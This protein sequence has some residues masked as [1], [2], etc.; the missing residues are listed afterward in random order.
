LGDSSGRLDELMGVSYELRRIAGQMR[1]AVLRFRIGGAWREQGGT[2]ARNYP[3]YESYLAHQRTKLDAMRASSLQS[4]DARFFHALRVRL[5]LLP[6]SLRG[7]SVL[8]LAAR[9]G[10]EVRA[11]IDAGAF[12]IGID[13]NPGRENRYVVTGDFHALQFATGS[14]EI[15]Y[16]NSLDHSFDFDRSVGEVL[17]VL[18]DDGYFIV[19]AGRGVEAGDEPG[20]YESFG[21]ASPDVLLDA[22]AERGFI[23]ENRSGLDVPW[24]GVQFVLRKA[25]PIPDDNG[26]KRLGARVPSAAQ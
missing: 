22:I 14:V 26:V 1:K 21:W 9:Q 20:F 4:H 19:E 6:F 5:S 2:W 3:D 18:S 15:V 17:R 24:R 12:A 8:C 7:R 11:F 23:L 10:S 25:T 16:T 13:L